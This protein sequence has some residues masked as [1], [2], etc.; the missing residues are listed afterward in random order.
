MKNTFRLT[1]EQIRRAANMAL[2]Q[3]SVE[4]F[5]PLKDGEKVKIDFRKIRKLP[6]YADMQPEYKEFVEKN[7]RRKF[8]VKTYEKYAPDNMIVT[9]Y[10]DS[11][12]DFTELT[13]IRLESNRY[14]NKIKTV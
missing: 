10:E 2:L 9:F 1:G 6:D 3:E 14:D 13:L 7:K 8:T 12:W 4:N 11:T 5:V